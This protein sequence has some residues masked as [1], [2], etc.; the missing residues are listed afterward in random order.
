[1]YKSPKALPR[2][3]RNNNPGNLRHNR[4]QRWQGEV[5]GAD[6]AFCTFITMAHGYRALMITLRT[7]MTKHG[8]HTVAKIITRWAPMR[9][10]DT[11]AYI[12]AVC[13]YTGYGPDDRLEPTKEVL[14]ALAAAIS[15][16]EN[17][18]GAE[19]EDVEEGWRLIT[20]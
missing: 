6:P 14:T 1:M 16:H 15:R 4:L 20:L 8:L 3:L 12:R 17:G 7:Y 19:P 5:S 9:E 11:P 10:N 2:G 13:R 18:L